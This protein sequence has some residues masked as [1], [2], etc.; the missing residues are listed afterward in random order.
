MDYLV[1]ELSDFVSLDGL[2]YLES[3]VMYAG[4]RGPVRSDA[5]PTPTERL[6]TRNRAS[7]TTGRRRA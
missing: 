7:S 1:C 3:T 5:D 6:A 4:Q 2:E